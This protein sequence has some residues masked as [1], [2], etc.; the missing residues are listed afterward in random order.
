MELSGS[1]ALV[2]GASSGIG[3]ELARA[4]AARGV[5]L[6]LTARSHEKL[7]SLARELEQKLRIE[8]R[9][10]IGDLAR[11][12]GAA[13]LGSDVDAL[14]LEVD[15]LIANAG[16]GDA[17]A[18]SRA[19]PDKL[20]EMLRVNCEAVVVLTR[21]FLPRML[22]RGRGG[23]L[24]VASTASFQPM[25][26]M[27]TYGATKAFVTSFAG[28]LAEEVRGTGVRV[29]ALCPGPVPTGFQ[30]AAGIEPGMERVAA[31][32]AEETA[33]RG[34]VAYLA[35]E[36]LC[37]P[38]VVNRA[39]TLVSKVMPRRMVASAVSFAMKRSGRAK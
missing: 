8:T 14:G 32:S 7:E 34:V 11:P 18:V 6:V 10:V 20:V 36:E 3:A 27:A 22:S 21:H 29:T 4:L 23:V 2:T 28:A 31:L 19:D 24:F 5:N 17:G 9:V 33:E 13:A 26:F 30:A 12:D 25:P 37:V 35:G 38:G 1:W 39:Q 15:H 16:F